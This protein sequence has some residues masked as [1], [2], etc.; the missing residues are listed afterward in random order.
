M[1]YASYSFA[2]SCYASHVILDLVS[3]F[4]FSF[5]GFAVFL[6]A[7]VLSDLVS[8]ALV[9]PI[10][11]IV[12]LVANKNLVNF[13]EILSLSSLSTDSPQQLPIIPNCRLAILSQIL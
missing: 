5:R 12:L 10:T 4:C 9:C 7:P 11:P 2:L 1:L 8:L 6:I 13:N 3:T